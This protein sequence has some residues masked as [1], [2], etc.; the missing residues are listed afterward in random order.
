MSPSSSTYSQRRLALLW[1]VCAAPLTAALVI[2]TLTGKLLDPAPVWQ[3]YAPLV[4]PTLLLMLGALRPTAA[5]QV[6]A[7]SFYFRLCWALS[8]FYWLC[9][10]LTVGA[11]LWIQSTTTTL[12]PDILKKGTLFLAIL[13]GLVG[14]A[15]GAFFTTSPA[16]AAKPG[17]APTTPVAAASS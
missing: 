15:L 6:S 5:P 4:A 3:W 7:D 2:G 14:Y 12:L 11:G 13:Q 9:L 17:A 10:Y 16:P 8:L 1:F